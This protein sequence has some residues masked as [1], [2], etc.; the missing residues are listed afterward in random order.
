MST[1]RRRNLIEAMHRADAWCP[2]RCHRLPRRF[3]VAIRRAERSLDSEEQGVRDEIGFLA[4]HTAYADRFFPGTSVQQTRLRYIFFVPWLYLDIAVQRPRRRVADLVRDAELRLV[5]RLLKAGN[6]VI[7]RRSHPKPAAQP[8][9]MIYWGALRRWGLLRSPGPGASPPDRARFHALLSERRADTN[10]HSDDHDLLDEIPALFCALP[11]PPPGWSDPRQPLAFTL[12]PAERR[13]ARERMI[14]VERSQDRR[15]SLLSRLAE[16]EFD[17][18]ND[19]PLW[20]ENVRRLAD[21][22]DQQAL[23]RARRVAALAAIGRAVYAS[24]VET[25]REQDGHPTPVDHRT[26]L[27]AVVAGHR[28]LA[29]ALD[30]DRVID[31]EP[32]LESQTILLQVLRQTQQWIRAGTKDVMALRDVYA[33]SEE[34]RK[35]RRARLTSRLFSKQRREEWLAKDLPEAQPLYYRWGNVRRLLQDL[36]GTA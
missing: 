21:V 8:P 2:P 14:S 36:R 11:E 6:G 4:L 13:V 10:L 35:G 19:A 31:D 25:L 18:P 1:D 9:S 33:Q 5:T 27:D 17:L 26:T 24:L 29:L 28:D 15:P 20:I 23:K 3:G 22:E 12:T 16:A 32:F 7:G 30:V 34:G